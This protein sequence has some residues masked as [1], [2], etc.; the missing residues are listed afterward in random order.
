MNK[1]ISHSIV[2]AVAFLLGVGVVFFLKAINSDYVY[3]TSNKALLAQ[4]EGDNAV[5]INWSSLLPERD[6]DLLT[7][8]Q[9]SQLMPLN[10]QILTSLQA[11]NDDDYKASLISNDTVTTHV[12]QSVEISGFIVPVDV[13]ED[14]RVIRFFLV[15]YFGACLHYPPPPPNQIIHVST[16]E[17]FTEFDLNQAYTISGIL[18]LCLFEDPLGTAAYSFDLVKIELYDGEPDDVRQH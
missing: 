18:R 16:E 15:P 6:R 1:L 14:Q 11:A 7:K 5:K 3:T 8:Y 12:D 17:G 2:I 4:Y 13:T 9:I 10:E